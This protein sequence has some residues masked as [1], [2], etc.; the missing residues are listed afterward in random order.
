[1]TF[2]KEVWVMIVCS[3]GQGRTSFLA[4]QEMILFLVVSGMMKFDLAREM[5]EFVVVM[6]QICLLLVPVSMLSKT[7]VFPTMIGL[8]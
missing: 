7:S 3:G 2:S 1:M 4:D 6:D 5:I 8:V